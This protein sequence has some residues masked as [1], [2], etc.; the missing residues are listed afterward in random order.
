M[1]RWDC[2]AYGSATENGCKALIKRDC[3]N[4]K[5]YKTTNDNETE[6]QNC[7]L[8]IRRIYGMST[9]N[10]LYIRRNEND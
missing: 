9:K 10:F 7:E 4:C 6:K 5:F 3:D 8:R 1:V 2:F